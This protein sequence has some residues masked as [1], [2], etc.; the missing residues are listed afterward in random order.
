[1]NIKEVKAKFDEVDLRKSIAYRAAAI[2]AVILVLSCIIRVGYV[3]HQEENQV[4]ISSPLSELDEPADVNAGWYVHNDDGSLKEISL[5]CKMPANADGKL[6]IS[7]TLNDLDA[8]HAC[9]KLGQN[10]YGIRAYI[11]GDLI[12]QVNT[13]K[14]SRQLMF[15]TISLIELPDNANGHKL[16]LVFS[17]SRDG[18]YK[19]PE[20]SRDSIGAFRYGLAVGDMY[21]L[22]VIVLM[23]VLGMVLVITHFMYRVREYDEPRLLCLAEFLLFAATWGF[24]DSWLPLLFGMSS[25]MSGILCYSS[26]VGLVI[27]MTIFIWMTCGRKGHIL[28]VMACVG[29]IDVF[30]QIILS[31]LGIVKMDSMIAVSHGV[32]FVAIIIAFLELSKVFLDNKVSKELT[33]TFC[34]GVVLA[35][36]SIVTLLMYW[37]GDDS[38]Y[39][40][41]LMTGMLFFLIMFFVGIVI[42]HNEDRAAERES[43]QNAEINKRLSFYDQLTGLM[44]R[45]AFEMKLGEM[46]VRDYNMDTALIM[47]DLNGLKVTN[48]SYGHAAGDDLIVAAAR[49]IE[50]TYGKEGS[51]YR[52]G[53]DEFA[54]IIENPSKSMASYDE[55]LEERMS[56]INMTS[57][58]KLSIAR[59]VSYLYDAEGKKQAVSDW[60]LEADVQMYRDK[61]SNSPH[62][63]RDMVSGLQD[64]INCVITTVEAKDMYTAAHSERVRELSSLLGSKLGLSEPTVRDLEAAAYLHDIGKIGV[65]DSV[66]KK[67]GRLTEDEFA[68]MAKH[69]EIGAEIIGQA[70][71]FK[72]T[73]DIILHHHERF[74]GKGYP[75]GIAGHDIPLQSRIIAVADSIDAMTSK[76]VYR[77]RLSIDDCKSQLQKFSGKMYDPA[78]IQIAMENWEDIQDI[79]LLHPKRLIS[80]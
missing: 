74:D 23:F 28:P 80:K 15:S 55:K 14:L 56:E 32:I 47:M 68:L 10:R 70:Q 5:P 29:L 31:Y 13:T 17:G 21:T 78:I 37:T 53:G 39:R 50:A 22:I 65:P 72:E 8:Q 4:G 24:C 57:K 73:A 27:P 69:C 20:A 40:N 6:V 44:N 3:M 33:M 42:R 77:D 25:E 41:C 7:T 67:P 60:K 36:A 54:V 48:D 18:E 71:G 30:S 75:D 66:L 26:L 49:T 43:L 46:E 61:I 62:V 45:R 1:M 58:W 16:T 38:S 51:C 19:L 35:G 12:Y 59:G 64:I 2:I 63:S 52:I 79:V 34:G 76:R 11:N 9:I